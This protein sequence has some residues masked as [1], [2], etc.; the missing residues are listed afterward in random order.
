MEKEPISGCENDPA[1]TGVPFFSDAPASSEQDSAENGA[2]LAP[3]PAP[4]AD[5]S[6]EPPL[7]AAG[8]DVALALLLLACGYLFCRLI[9]EAPPG[10]GVTVFF[11]VFSVIALF[12]L[13]PKGFSKGSAACFVL[14]GL[15]ALQF[16]VLSNPNLQ[17]FLLLFLM[18]CVVYSVAAVCGTRLEPK[19]GGLFLADL[20]NQIWNVPFRNFFCN[21]RVLFARKNRR[22]KT[23]LA[24][25]IGVVI[26]LP[27]L[28]VIATLLVSADAAFESVASSLLGWLEEQFARFLVWLLPSF[29]IGCYLFGLLYG[30]RHSRCA[31]SIT[32]EKAT[33]ARRA[34]QVLPA[35]A[36]A[37]TLGLV[38]ALYGFFLAVQAVSVVQSCF[39]GGPL[40]VSYAEY[41]RR[42]FFELCGLAF[43]N[44]LIMT[45]A[46][47]FTRTGAGAPLSQRILFALLSVETLLLIVT[48]VSK[49]LL[50]VRRYGLT[51]KRVYTLWIMAVLFLVFC[52]IFI[53]QIK[54]IPFLR[55]ATLVCSISFLLLCYA[56]VDGL[57]TRYNIAAYESGALQELDVSAFYAMP[58]GALPQAASLYDRLPEGTLKLRVGEFLM[59]AKQR[60]SREDWRG[61]SI[62]QLSAAATAL[63][64]ELREWEPQVD[65]ASRP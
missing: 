10:L 15:A 35:A 14:T 49:M 63:P 50:Y 61:W 24:V 1:A 32:S 54:P 6:P 43:F 48:A 5:C 16:S 3:P 27:L 21:F 41:A 17:P 25:L 42:G 8:R 62:Q 4:P 31:D 45:A 19:L 47:L 34:A 37:T 26:A 30:N 39:A 22:A 28:A 38:C 56:N 46:W 33:G 52:L 18:G 7:P 60:L 58:A 9:L 64:E 36:F 12:Y 13:A 55:V 20:T 2:L 44:L 51:Q 11:S 29:L 65:W 59:D 53:R 40:S 57:I 23:A